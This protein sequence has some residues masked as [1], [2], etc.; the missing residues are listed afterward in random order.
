M[1]FFRLRGALIPNRATPRSHR[2]HPLLA[3]VGV[4][5]GGGQ[6]HMSQQGL[7]V[8]PFR[9]AIMDRKRVYV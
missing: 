2:R 3:H 8:H 4:K 9:P 1:K 7:D 6:I 5:L